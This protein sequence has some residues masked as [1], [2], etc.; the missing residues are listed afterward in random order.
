MRMSILEYYEYS[1]LYLVDTKLSDQYLFS[2]NPHILSVLMAEYSFICCIFCFCLIRNLA[3]N[4]FIYLISRELSPECLWRAGGEL[5]GYT[6]QPH[7]LRRCQQHHYTETGGS[8]EMWVCCCWCFCFFGFVFLTSSE[9]SSQF[10]VVSFCGGLGMSIDL[11]VR[12]HP[13]LP[14]PLMSPT[15]IFLEYEL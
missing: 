5:S 2:H 11:I 9:F 14:F 6:Q 10:G 4:L 1:C 7:I 13:L 15:V 8:H 3:Y 12:S